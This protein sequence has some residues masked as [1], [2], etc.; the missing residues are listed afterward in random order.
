[1]ELID[2]NELGLGE[3]ELSFHLQP[4]KKIELPKCPLYTVFQYFRDLYSISE[5]KRLSFGVEIDSAYIYVVGT[6]VSYDLF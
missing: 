5:S 2:F 3:D 1:M 6:E 4:D